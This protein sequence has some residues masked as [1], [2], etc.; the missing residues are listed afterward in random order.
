MR[1]KM[2]SDAHGWV[3]VSHCAARRY[4]KGGRMIGPFS[5]GDVPFDLVRKGITNTAITA[6]IAAWRVRQSQ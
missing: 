4:A 1:F 2:W 6:R 5:N 3:Q